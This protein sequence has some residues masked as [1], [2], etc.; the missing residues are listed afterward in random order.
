M[1][2]V[3][4]LANTS[5]GRLYVSSNIVEALKF[6]NLFGVR[7]DKSKRKAINFYITVKN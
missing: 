3:E 7:I 6:A 2:T 1:K 4:F 5:E